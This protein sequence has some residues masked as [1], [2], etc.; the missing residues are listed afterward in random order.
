MNVFQGLFASLRLW[1]A[2]SVADRAH[3]TNGHRYYVMPISRSNG[4]LIIMDRQNFRLLKM[5]GYIPNMA[6]IA[7][8]EQECFYCTPY[9][10]GSGALTKKDTAFKASQYFKW[11]AAAAKGR[12]EWKKRLH[13]LSPLSVPSLQGSV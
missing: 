8:L 1:R 13:S 10:N 12:K 6:L 3:R 2:V 11:C 9:A 7:N 5:K 4:K